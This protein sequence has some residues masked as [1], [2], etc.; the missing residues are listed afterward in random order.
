[1]LEPHDQIAVNTLFLLFLIMG[2]GFWVIKK[3][4]DNAFDIEQLQIQMKQIIKRLRHSLPNSVDL[5]KMQADIIEQNQ[6][7]INIDAK[8]KMK[9]D[10]IDERLEQILKVVMKNMSE[11]E[12]FDAFTT[13]AGDSVTI[14]PDGSYVIDYEDNTDSHLKVISTVQDAIDNIGKK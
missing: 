8:Y 13:G 3:H 6:N 10:D 5:S 1:M 11:K 9:Y 12:I 7:S 2:F 14:N 4:Y